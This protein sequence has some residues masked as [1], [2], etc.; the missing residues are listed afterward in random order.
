MTSGFRTISLMIILLAASLDAA[1]QENTH[2]TRQHSHPKYAT[3]V[4]PVAKTGES[5]ALGKEMYRKHC[6]AC[7]GEAGKG[8]SGPALTAAVRL[9]GSTEGE[10]FHVIT[11]GVAK[12]AMKGMRS[13]LT[14]EMR[15]DLVNY[16]ESLKKK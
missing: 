2:K 15:W 5:L 16:I 6:V 1:A 14:D 13:K 4:N 8:G 10:L 12:T 9:H 7:H 11:D 3:L